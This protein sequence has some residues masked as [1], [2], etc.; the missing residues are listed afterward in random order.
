MRTKLSSEVPTHYQS[1]SIAAFG[2][3][4]KMHM[5]GSMSCSFEFKTKKEATEYM[6]RIADKLAENDKELRE[7][8]SDIKNGRLYYDAAV[9]KMERV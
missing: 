1:R 6:L 4:V 7:M 9:L 2:M 3:P 8:V 5:D